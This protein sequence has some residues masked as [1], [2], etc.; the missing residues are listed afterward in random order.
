MEELLVKINN[1]ITFSKLNNALYKVD[2]DDFSV[3][4]LI[5]EFMSHMGSIEKYSEVLNNVLAEE[6]LKRSIVEKFLKLIPENTL[7]E[8]AIILKH[9]SAKGEIIYTVSKLQTNEFGDG[10][11]YSAIDSKMI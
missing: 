3:Y 6:I 11:I 9:I 2:Y 4:K 5:D 1:E 7:I 8:N 10:I